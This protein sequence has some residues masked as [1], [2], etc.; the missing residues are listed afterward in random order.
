M[1]EHWEAAGD[2]DR[3]RTERF[4]PIIG[5]GD[6]E[7]GS[8]G[9]VRFRITDF[10]AK[11]EPGVSILVGGEEAGGNLPYGCRMGI[12]HTCIGKLRERSGARPADG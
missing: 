1:E 7:V 6:E 9:T 12:C 3:L 4:Q 8:G 2:P 11:C 5:T 10:E